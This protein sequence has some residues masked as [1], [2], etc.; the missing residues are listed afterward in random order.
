MDVRRLGTADPFTGTR[1]GR[2]WVGGKR[3]FLDFRHPERALVLRIK[4]GYDY[5][6]V[7]IETD[8]PASLLDAIRAKIST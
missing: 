7:A 8:H 1:K 6:V 2:F 3:L 4:P 5:D